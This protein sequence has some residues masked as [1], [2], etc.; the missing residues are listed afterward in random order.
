MLIS[1]PVKFLVWALL[2]LDLNL[3]GKRM[4]SICVRLA[5]GGMPGCFSGC[6]VWEQCVGQGEFVAA[7]DVWLC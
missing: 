3:Q 1:A 5:L 2:M 4:K 6:L 7:C